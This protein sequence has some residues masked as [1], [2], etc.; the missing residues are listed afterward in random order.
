MLRRTAERSD[1]QA[2]RSG[3][4]AHVTVHLHQ[5]PWGLKDARPWR[6]QE[7][8]GGA[9]DRVAHSGVLSDVYAS[10]MLHD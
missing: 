8:G 4:A 9:E 1:R 3:H 5:E 6:L 7:G 2:K 10:G